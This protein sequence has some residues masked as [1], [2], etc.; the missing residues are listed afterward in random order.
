M[1]QQ[2]LQAHVLPEAK[3]AAGHLREAGQASLD[4]FLPMVLHM[5]GY[6]IVVVVLYALPCIQMNGHNKV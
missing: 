6:S 5:A 4:G 3:V 2:H 1:A